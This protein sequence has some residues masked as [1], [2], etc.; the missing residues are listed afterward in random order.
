MSRGALR[1]AGRRWPPARQASRGVLRTLR[2]TCDC[3]PPWEACRFRPTLGEV[4]ESHSPRWALCEVL[5]ISEADRLHHA[6]QGPKGAER[7]EAKRATAHA[8][9][10]RRRPIPDTWLRTFLRVQPLLLTH[11]PALS[12]TWCPFVE[13]NTRSVICLTGGLEVAF[14]TLPAPADVPGTWLQSRAAARGALRTTW[15]VA[16]HC[17]RQPLPGRRLRL[18]AALRRPGLRQDTLTGSLLH[19][20]AP[21]TPHHLSRRSRAGP[22]VSTM[23][24][25]MSCAD[26]DDRMRSRRPR[27]P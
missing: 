16:T 20:R 23:M 22:S 5:R 21:N 12:Y 14:Q 18:L 6:E 9:C 1:Q 4:G 17:F 7:S 24:K 25:T 3:R 2:G 15:F 26:L 8:F 10:R 13:I 11:P 27:L 19:P